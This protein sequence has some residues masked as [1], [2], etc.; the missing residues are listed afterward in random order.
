MVVTSFPLCRAC[1]A[2]ILGLMNLR[3]SAS[4]EGLLVQHWKSPQGVGWHWEPG[5]ANRPASRTAFLLGGP[6]VDNGPE[7]GKLREMHREWK[8]RR[9]EEEEWEA[10]QEGQGSLSRA[11]VSP[12]R[13]VGVG[14]PAPTSPILLAQA[15]GVA[16]GFQQWGQQPDQGEWERWERRNRPVTSN[17]NRIPRIF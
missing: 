5:P 10:R 8:H 12:G 4:C 3:A 7:T 1:V 6:C 9:H 16:G 2:S 17:S 13:S 14:P 15:D 11:E